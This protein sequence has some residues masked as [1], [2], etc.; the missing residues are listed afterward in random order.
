LSTPVGLQVFFVR[1]LL[2]L[3]VEVWKEQDPSSFSIPGQR[4]AKKESGAMLGSMRV[5]LDISRLMCAQLSKTCPADKQW[6]LPVRTIFARYFMVHFPLGA[7]M[8]LKDTPEGVSMELMNL[9]LAEVMA[10]LASS[11]EGGSSKGPQL[12]GALILPHEPKTPGKSNGSGSNSNSRNSTPA[13]SHGKGA[14]GRGSGGAPRTPVSALATEMAGYTAA[15]DRRAALQAASEAG[16]GPSADYKTVTT[17][18]LGL[19]D[20]LA[21]VK[22]AGSGG[23]SGG[24]GGGGTSTGGG[25]GG[26]MVGASAARNWSVLQ[27]LLVICKQAIKVDPDGSVDIFTGLYRLYSSGACSNTS[28]EKRALLDFFAGYLSG[29]ANSKTRGHHHQLPAQSHSVLVQWASSLPKLL[30]SL[31][32]NCIPTSEAALATLVHAGARRYLAAPRTVLG[33]CVC[34]CVCVGG[35]AR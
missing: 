25:G 17:F 35:G 15:S 10:Y 32:G 14:G 9:R 31:K 28:K 7:D 21:V 30:W 8:M 2:P 3:L 18:V 12:G 33:V 6:V 13:K 23:S 5:I 4:V 34:V 19:V 24:G 26:S 29:E 20:R 16:G 1:E 27:V 11:V 22:K